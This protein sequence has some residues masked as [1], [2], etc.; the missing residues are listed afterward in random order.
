M[1]IAIITRLIH[2]T[3]AQSLVVSLLQGRQR[4]KLARE[5]EQLPRRLQRDVGWPPRKKRAGD[6]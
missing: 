4:A 6:L 3:G 5:M 1:L 2:A